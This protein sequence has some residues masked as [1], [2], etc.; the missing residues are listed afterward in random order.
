[1]MNGYDSEVIIEILFV[2]TFEDHNYFSCVVGAFAFSLLFL[3]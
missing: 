3:I 1:M 2:I